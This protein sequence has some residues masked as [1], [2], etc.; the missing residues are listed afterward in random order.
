[1]KMF[2]FTRFFDMASKLEHLVYSS[3][4]ISI[5]KRVMPGHTLIHM[6][7]T[8]SSR[9]TTGFN[10]TLNPINNSLTYQPMNNI[11]SSTITDIKFPDIDAKDYDDTELLLILGKKYTDDRIYDRLLISN[12]HENQ[13]KSF[14]KEL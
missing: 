7:T 2:E 5:S 6:R 1:M 3:D 9:Y 13:I 8:Y 14:I 10:L 12:T 11:F 4:L